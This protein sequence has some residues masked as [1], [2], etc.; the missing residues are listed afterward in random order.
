MIHPSAIVEPGA[1]L[2]AG[3]EIM[4]GAIVMRHCALEIGRAHV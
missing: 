3:C 1:R 4:A 2:G